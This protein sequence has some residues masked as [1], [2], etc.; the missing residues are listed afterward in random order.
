MFRH[1]P[2]ARF[3]ENALTNLAK[4]MVDSANDRTPETA[5]PQDDEENT[6]ISAGYTYFGQFVDHDLTFDPTS[7]RQKQND[8]DAIVDF[9]TPRFDLDCVYGRGPDAQPYMYRGDGRHFLLGDPLSGNSS[10]PH[11]AGLARNIPHKLNGN[12][13][14][15]RALIG[16]PRN[17]ENVIVSQLQAHMLRFHNRMADLMPD[18]P[19][20]QVQQEVRWHY[21]WCVLNDFLPTI[22][23]HKL[24]DQIFNQG[25]PELRFYRPRKSPYMPVEFSVAADRFG[26]SMVRPFSRSNQR[27]GQE[28]DRLPIFSLTM[29][30][31]VGFGQTPSNLAIDWR[32][33]FP[34]ESNIPFTPKRLQPAYKIDTSLVNP[35]GD[36]PPEIA[37]D[38]SS[39]AARNLL[40]SLKMGLPSG[41]AV[42]HA[43]GSQPLRT[44]ELKIGKLTEADFSSEPSLASLSPEFKHDAPLWVY[45]L[46]ETAQQ[47]TAS[48]RNSTPIRLGP[49]G[50]R[51]V[52]EVF[53]GLM[54]FDGGAYI[55]AKPDFKPRPEFSNAKTGRFD[56]LD[57]LLS[58]EK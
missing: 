35:L 45:I 33:F 2:A 44:D 57:L 19:F 40:R 41:Q 7:L 42:A 47:F 53:I 23:G 37:V 5:N 25:D 20:H 49:V 14:P 18:E 11:A 13:E 32:L 48:P 43:L 10:D 54:H 26:H 29:P 55:N 30:S 16:D 21:Q 15:A 28:S 24:T 12:T 8:P 3:S 39:L 1:L 22:I 34:N 50:G 46:A 51:I 4:K 6:G 58:A 27:T 31:L 36:L 9:R 52:G 56:I 17:D 38:P